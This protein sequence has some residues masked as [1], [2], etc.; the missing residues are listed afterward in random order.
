[1]QTYQTYRILV[2]DGRKEYLEQALESFGRLMTP[3]P[4]GTIVVDDSQ[5]AAF[6]EWLDA[7]F[8]GPHDIVKHHPVKVGLC[9]SM[10]WAWK[11]VPSDCEYIQHLE[12]DFILEQPV[13]MDDIIYVLERNHWLCQIWLMRHPWYA[14]EVE[15]GGIYQH[16][17]PQAWQVRSINNEDATP[18]YPL[19]WT[20][21]NWGRFWTQNPC[22]YSKRVTTRGY[23]MGPYCEEAVAQ[24]MWDHGLKSAFWGRPDEFP[25]ARHIGHIS[26]KVKDF[27]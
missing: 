6:A 3:A 23:P 13:N 25:R 11:N 4:K 19:Y 14:K 26:R 8:K 27:Y 22:V 12:E 20:E 7:T 21:Y 15:A 9:A 10:E 2:S 5:D 1:M 24:W 17:A 18:A 16:R